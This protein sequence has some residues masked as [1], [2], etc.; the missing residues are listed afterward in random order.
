M[1]Y[2]ITDTTD[3]NAKNKIHGAVVRHMSALRMVPN[4]SLIPAYNSQTIGTTISELV[5]NTERPKRMIIAG[6]F[7]PPDNKAGTKDNAR[8]DFFCAE[9]GDGIVVCGTCNGTEFSYIKPMIKKFYRLTNTNHLKSQFRS[10]QVLPKHAILFSNLR[11]RKKLIRDGKLELIEDVDSFIPSVPKPKH[12]MEVDNF[13][14]VKLCLSPEDRKLVEELAAKKASVY[15]AFGKA[16]IEATGIGVKAEVG[17]YYEATAADT[18]FAAPWN[19]NVLGARSSS[20]LVDG[21]NVPVVATIRPRPG[22]TRPVF[23]ADLPPVGA[24]VFLTATRPERVV[25]GAKLDI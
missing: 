5:T 4:F 1:Y 22:E 24:E 13:G 8:N 7:A 23:D 18:L 17:P 2:Q 15:F 25:E 14:N 20:T 16:A 21:Q 19:T 9:L 10:L 6:N 12:V 11:E 3:Q